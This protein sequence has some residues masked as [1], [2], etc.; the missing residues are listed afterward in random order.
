MAHVITAD[1]HR[2]VM[3][4]IL[5]LIV[6]RRANRVRGVRH[7]VRVRVVPVISRV[8]R[9]R[10]GMVHPVHHVVTGII[11]Q[12]SAMLRKHR[13]AMVMDVI[14]ATI[15]QIILNTL[16]VQHQIHVHGHVMR[17]T[18]VLRQMGIH[19]VRT[20]VRVITVPA[21]RTVPHVQ[22]LL[23]PAPQPPAVS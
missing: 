19:H 15:N 8:Q 13:L 2:H 14:H 21:E 18:M 10:I 20:V 9:E 1:Q 23:N 7:G 16:A 17:D 22:Q 3:V 12:D 5:I 4:T 6:I 11:V